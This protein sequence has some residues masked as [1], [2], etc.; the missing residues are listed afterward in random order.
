MQPLKF[1]YRPL[2]VLVVC[3]CS[4]I[5]YHSLFT[6][7]D[8]FEQREIC[9]RSESR[10]ELTVSDS[11]THVDDLTSQDLAHPHRPVDQISRTRQS[12]LL[13]QPHTP[14]P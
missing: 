7:F 1:A 12:R 11:H 4:Y 14:L 6:S 10:G 5:L 13:S 8:P 3:F 9:P 2:L